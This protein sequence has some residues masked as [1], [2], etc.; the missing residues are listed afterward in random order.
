MPGAVFSFEVEYSNLS[1]SDLNLLLFS[2]VLWDDTC[3]KL[4]MG[5]PVGLG[6]A[7]IEITTLAT[8]DR[9][10]R[11]RRFAA[12]WANLEGETLRTFVLNRA[13]ALRTSASPN[14]D[15]LHRILR[16]DENAPDIVRYPSRE[17]F[18]KNPRAPL[19]EAP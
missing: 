11:Y 9:H 18:G 4:G 10:N 2:L 6:S 5:K 3:H 19:E 15:D 7:K 1:E 8:L 17:W 16:W 14:L 12:G 13:G